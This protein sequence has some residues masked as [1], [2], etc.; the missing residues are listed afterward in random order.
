MDIFSGSGIVSHFWTF[1]PCL[2]VALIYLFGATAGKRKSIAGA[3]QN[4]SEGMSKDNEEVVDKSSYCA[5][6][7]IAQDDEVKL[8]DC[9]GCDIVRYCSDACQRDH[10]SEHEEECKKRVAEL[11]DELLFRQPESTHLGDCP[12]CSLPLSLDMSK[13]VMYECCSKFICKGCSHANW[14]RED[15]MRLQHTCPFCREPLTNVEEEAMKRLMKRVEANDPDAMY[16]RGGEQYNEGEYQSAFEY[17]TKAAALGD[18]DAHYQLSNMYYDGKCVKKDEGK[19]IHHA[20]EAAIGGH[21]QARYNLGY[22]EWKQGNHERAVKHLIISAK[23]G[24]DK[25][26]KELMNAFKEGYVEKEVL[27]STLRA[28]QAAVDATKSP[29]REEGEKC[30]L[31][32]QSKVGSQEV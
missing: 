2:I 17:F 18:A 15:K 4:K 9:A 32:Y 1:C 23:L 16:Q 14:M 19:H 25:A 20:E 30:R 11:R 31:P 12:L 21:P 6:C 3:N 26:I 8:K 28:H 5:S 29:Q 27:A 7:G 10:K 22:E 13:S 24:E